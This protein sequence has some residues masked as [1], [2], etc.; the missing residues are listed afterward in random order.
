MYLKP[1]LVVVE[2]VLVEVETQ[3]DKA[4]KENA[5]EVVETC[6]CKLMLAVVG[7][8]SAFFPTTSPD[9]PKK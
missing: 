6:T 5:R 7:V 3:N 4:G 1:V 2:N 8:Q 9:E